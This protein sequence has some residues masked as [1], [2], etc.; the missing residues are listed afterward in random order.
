MIIQI[1]GEVEEN[2][3]FLY[4]IEKKTVTF[5]KK[6]GVANSIH[7]N[8]VDKDGSCWQFDDSDEVIVL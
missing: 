3:S 7:F 5:T 8:A 6:T 4:D 2:K 1:F